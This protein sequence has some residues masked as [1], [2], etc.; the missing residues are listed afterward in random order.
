MASPDSPPDPRRNESAEPS[1]ASDSHAVPDSR[2]MDRSDDR[3][4]PGAAFEL[5]EL[6]DDAFVIS[7]A[8]DDNRHDSPE[9]RLRETVSGSTEAP[10]PSASDPD[11][12]FPL[13]TMIA[14]RYRVAG[15]IARGGMG[16]V[17][18]TW[19]THIGRMCAMKVLR[20]SHMQNSVL[21]RRFECEARLNALLQHPGIVPMHDM[22]LLNSELHFFTMLLVEG[23]TFEKLLA[24]RS[25]ADEHLPRLLQV[26]HRVSET[27]AYA[28]SRRIVHRDIKPQ[29]VMVANYGVVKVMDWGLAKVLHQHGF[30]FPRFVLTEDE[31]DGGLIQDTDPKFSSPPDTQHGMVFGTLSYAPPEQVNGHNSHVD[32]RA[33]VFALGGVLCE[34]LTGFPTYRRDSL[35]SL[36]KA[37]SHADLADAR[38]RLDQCRAERPLVE[39]AHRCLQADPADRLRNAGEVSQAISAYL[40]SDLRRAERDQVRFFDLCM[41]LFCIAGL[42]GYFRRVNVNFERVLGYSRS[43]LLAQ[44]FEEFVHPDDRRATAE[45]VRQLE[46]G[47]PVVRFSNRYRHRDGH[48]VTLEWAA[49]SVPDEGVIYAVARDVTDPPPVG[50]WTLNVPPHG[51]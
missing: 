12:E 11:V 7:R 20:R 30:D 51:A 49:Q 48:F 46:N 13:N 22:D 15:E 32:E 37:A 50:G 21:Q 39:I 24:R 40:E 1:A 14:G 4:R 5:S 47:I 25:D 35:A 16:M 41:D 10:G 8:I 2:P 34:I 26:F 28:H 31:V 33:D 38:G 17:L 45:A 36:Y 6:T 29:N 44:P 19:D 27:I 3:Q 43:E 42:N 9:S 18:K 23:E